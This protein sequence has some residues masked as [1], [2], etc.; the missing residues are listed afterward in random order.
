MMFQDFLVT[1]REATQLPIGDAIPIVML[2]SCINAK[3]VEAIRNSFDSEDDFNEEGAQIAALTTILQ[4]AGFI[5]SKTI[6]GWSMSVGAFG[7]TWIMNMNLGFQYDPGI[8]R[9]LVVKNLINSL[10]IELGL[11]SVSYDPVVLSLTAMDRDWETQIH[12]HYPSFTLSC[13]VLSFILDPFSPVNAL[14]T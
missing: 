2:P 8:S 5:V 10:L 13:A 3:M 11:G 6:T 12:I 14:V 7:E 1:S 9:L 4:N